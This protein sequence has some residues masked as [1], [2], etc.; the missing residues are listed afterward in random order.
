[1]RT[2][3]RTLVLYLLCAVPNVPYVVPEAAAQDAQANTLPPP[4]DTIEVFDDRVE[5]H[6]AEV[7]LATVLR[8]LS[9]QG[10]R[11]IV[12]T[13]AVTG[14]VTADLYN[15]SFSEALKAILTANDCEHVLRDGCIYVYTAD[16]MAAIVAEQI[17]LGTQVFM[18][19]YVQAADAMAVL[20]PL[21]SE[22]G[23]ITKSAASE[24]GL[25]S[26][27]KTVG[28]DTLSGN[29]F[30]VVYDY[31]DN[32]ARIADVLAQI[33]VRPRQVLVEATILRARLTEDNALGI[34]FTLLAGVD[35][36]VLGATSRGIGDL[37][38]GQLPTDRLE[39]FNA[40]ATTRFTDNVPDGGLTLGI[41]KDQVAV[42]IRALEQITD[43]SVLANPKVL[44]LNKQIGNVIVGRR[45]G[46]ITTTVTETQAIQKVEFLETGTQLTFRP[47]IGTDGYIRMELHPEDSVGGLTAAQL[48]FEQTTEVTTNVIVRDGHTILIG[49][50]FREVTSESRSQ[51]PFFGDLPHIGDLFRSRSD[52]LDREEVIILLT[53]HIVHD[54]EIYAEESLDQLRN[55]ERARV[56]LRHGMMWHGRERLAQ[57]YYR[58]AVKFFGQGDTDRASWNVQM[59]LHNYPRFLSAIKLKEEIEQARNW[60]ED[61]TIGRDAVYELIRRENGI[62][63]RVLGRPVQ[64]FEPAEPAS[65][66]SGQ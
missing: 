29:D 40:N 13:P 60:E 2:A 15:V 45:D 28:G 20:E 50:L 24:S 19:N 33:D 42:F 41:I 55:I 54:D 66:D 61:G 49:G 38:L 21:L 57:S 17:P 52:S 22:N 3:K 51:L 16:E 18:L 6:V 10:K 26:N 32:L 56:S 30:L 1:M 11:N 39:R 7:P 9:V 31:P 35:L 36:E 25:Q 34:D 23:K 64:P 53:V 65:T 27:S 47:F 59:C 37:L 14:T 62:D 44:T 12:A 4:G 46:Y 43:T 63:S 48:P 5:L 58:R 8:M